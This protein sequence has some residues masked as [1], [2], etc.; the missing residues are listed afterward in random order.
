MGKDAYLENSGSANFFAYV[1]NDPTNGT[2]SLGLM[3]IE[4][5]PPVVPVPPQ[6]SATN[7]WICGSELFPNDRGRPRWYLYYSEPIPIAGLGLDAET[8][9]CICYWKMARWEWLARIRWCRVV[10]CCGGCK[11]YTET[12]FNYG[13]ASE[14]VWGGEVRTTMGVWDSAQQRWLYCRYPD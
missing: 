14:P 9:V 12:A 4:G 3:V 7:W 2:D 1:Y 5:K 11:K 13:T 10:R 8:H 6:C